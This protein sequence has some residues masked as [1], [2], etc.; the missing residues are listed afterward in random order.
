MNNDQDINRLIA[1]G[2]V[3][4]GRVANLVAMRKPVLT[5]E[6]VAEARRELKCCSEYMAAAIDAAGEP[7]GDQE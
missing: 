3:T 1:N 2:A 7:V 6:Q 5:R 4:F